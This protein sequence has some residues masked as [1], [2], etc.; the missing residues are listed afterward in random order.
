MPPGLRERDLNPLRDDLADLIER[1]CAKTG[2]RLHVAHTVTV[3]PRTLEDVSDVVEWFLHRST[4]RLLSFLPAASVGRTEDTADP[5]V[6]MA[7]VWSCIERGARRSLNRD[8]M[9]FGH[10]LGEPRS[11]P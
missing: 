1:V 3:T 5:Q 8:A 9:H 10:H 4:F 2:E 11:P 6:T 7:E